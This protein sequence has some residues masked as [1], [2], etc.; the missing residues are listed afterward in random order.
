MTLG[1]GLVNL[2]C[3]R[4]S[5]EVFGKAAKY[6]KSQ[7]TAKQWQAYVLGEADRRDGL[8]ES[9]AKIEGCQLP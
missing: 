1:N 5:A 3:Y 9:G 6:K 7:K 2:N 4:K 8:I